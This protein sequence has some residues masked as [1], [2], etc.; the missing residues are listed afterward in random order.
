MINKSKPASSPQDSTNKQSDS[1]P[2]EDAKPAPSWPSTHPP[3]QVRKHTIPYK[4]VEQSHET[5][6]DRS[7]SRQHSTQKLSCCNGQD[8]DPTNSQSK[9][10]KTQGQL[11]FGESPPPVMG[12]HLEMSTSQIEC[13]WRVPRTHNRLA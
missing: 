7:N 3:P 13:E 9:T 12:P 4:D 5:E 11:C 2:K 1:S 10:D 6:H 8:Q